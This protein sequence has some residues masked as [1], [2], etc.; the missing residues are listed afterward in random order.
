MRKRMTTMLCVATVAAAVVPAAATANTMWWEI[1]QGLAPLADPVDLQGI[2]YDGTVLQLPEVE[3]LQVVD[4]KSGKA[5]TTISGSLQR[6]AEPTYVF[7]GAGATPDAVFYLPASADKN[8]VG[9][10]W[11]PTV[12]AALFD[13]NAFSEATRVLIDQQPVPAAAGTAVI[14]GNAAGRT[15]TIDD[16][17]PSP[18]EAEF[19][20]QFAAQWTALEGDIEAARQWIVDQE[21]PPTKDLKAVVIDIVPAYGEVDLSFLSCSVVAAEPDEA[22]RCPTDMAAATSS[23][24]AAAPSIHVPGPFIA[25]Y[26]DIVA[27]RPV[28]KSFIPDPQITAPACE[29]PPTLTSTFEGDTRGPGLDQPSTRTTIYHH[30]HWAAQ[31]NSFHPTVNDT[32]RIARTFLQLGLP[33]VAHEI[34]EVRRNAG[35]GGV[36]G[37][38]G[39]YYGEGTSLFGSQ[40]FQNVSMSNDSPNPFCVTSGILGISQKVESSPV[41]QASHGVGTFWERDGSLGYRFVHDQYPAH[42]SYTWGYHRTLGRQETPG[43]SYYYSPPGQGQAPC[44]V[45]LPV[46]GCQQIVVDIVRV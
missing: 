1:P 42:E 30:M 17:W 7:A 24:A 36:G 29:A 16:R 28:H 23:S 41:V 46:P 5:G 2:S 13:P 3:G 8:G 40:G 25:V 15:V 45:D 9:Y 21:A 20:A 38:S 10:V 39:Q 22:D 19:V 43:A 18:A 37:G 6:A 26:D 35:L 32:V 11:T 33:P 12:S 14:A 44:L 34:N 27:T 31:T 4:V